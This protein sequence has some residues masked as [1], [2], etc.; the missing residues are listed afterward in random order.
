M[1]GHIVR[2]IMA[3]HFS[4]PLRSFHSIVLTSSSV[5]RCPKRHDRGLWQ[6][7]LPISNVV[8]SNTTWSDFLERYTHT[9]THTHKHIHHFATFVRLCAFGYMNVWISALTWWQLPQMNFWWWSKLKENATW[10]QCV[11]ICISMKAHLL[12]LCFISFFIQA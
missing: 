12:G 2:N 8:R 7:E 11:L 5:A 3:I 4:A 10:N 6:W 9:H 1:H